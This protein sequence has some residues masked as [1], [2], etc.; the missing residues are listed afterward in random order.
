MRGCTAADRWN[1]VA[2]QAFRT[3][4]IRHCKAPSRP[5]ESQESAPSE[6]VCMTTMAPIWGLVTRV[7]MLSARRLP[8]W[9]YLQDRGKLEK[10]KKRVRWART[11]QI[12]GVWFLCLF[13][14]FGIRQVSLRALA[15]STT[16]NYEHF[17]SRKSAAFVIQILEQIA[18]ILRLKRNKEYSPQRS[19][20][21]FCHHPG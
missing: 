8:F 12:G 2:T 14:L 21:L 13:L 10:K 18:I 20:K 3:P 7:Y 15:K 1:G 6:W 16:S 17:Q 5:D 19:Y 11:N 4:H 9:R